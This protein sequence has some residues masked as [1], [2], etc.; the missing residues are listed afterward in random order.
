MVTAELMLKNHPT[1]WKLF[2]TDT[3]GKAL[4]GVTF[5][6]KK[7]DLPEEESGENKGQQDMTNAA[8]EEKTVTTADG[9]SVELK[10]LTPGVYQVQETET[11][12]GYILDTE[13]RYVTVDKEGFIFESDPEGKPLDED[14]AKSDTE[15]LRWTNELYQMGYF[16]DRYYRRSGTGRCSS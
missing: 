15:T 1:T 13:V 10:Y 9:G 11:L 7:Y 6:V 5:S 2:K 16:Q 8:S 4:D 14:R 3:T 12:P